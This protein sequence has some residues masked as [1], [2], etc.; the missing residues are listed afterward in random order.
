MPFL[1]LFALAWSLV[2]LGSDSSMGYGYYKQFESRHFPC[3]T[4]TITHSIAERHSSK[5]GVSYIAVINYQYKVNGQI[6]LGDRL[7]F[8]EG[9][10]GGAGNDQTIVQSHPVGST[11]QIYYNPKDPNESLLYPG[12]I[13]RDFAPL[14]FLAPFNMI[15][16]G[17]WIWVGR[18]LRL[19]LF[20]PVAGGV[21]IIPDDGLTTR[22]RLPQ[23]AAIWWGLG[24]VGVLG[25]IS[26]FAT[27]ILAQG[28]APV[29]SIF[30]VM[31]VYLAGAAIYVWRWRKNNSGDKDLVIHEASRALELPLTF[32][33]QERL[34]LR[35]SDIESV[36]VYTIVHSNKGSTY[37]YAPTLN[38]KDNQ[39]AQ[40]LA[41]WPDKLK[42]DKFVEWLGQK[43][44]AEWRV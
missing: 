43:I 11:A 41:N 24:T 39:P 19:R 7:E 10:L 6:F 34:T 1:I 32:G 36:W 44:G 27:A 15:T 25:F 3:V 40:K 16:L 28:K 21:K 23:M 42:A 26:M 35:F 38:L 20:K 13:N 18:W 8:D 2:T 5:G 22:V 37:T 4:G 9:G 12:I 14:L 31:A 33:R 17:F 30:P 29:I